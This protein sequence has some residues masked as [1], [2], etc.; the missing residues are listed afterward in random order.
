MEITIKR[1]I[2][3]EL[4]CYKIRVKLTSKGIRV[5]IV[6]LA[7]FVLSIVV[8]QNDYGITDT[9]LMIYLFLQIILLAFALL[10]FKNMYVNR[11][12]YKT[13]SKSA[14]VDYASLETYSTTTIDDKYLT[15]ESAR[16]YYKLS[17]S[18]LTLYQL[19]DGNLILMINSI[20]NSFVIRP[21]ELS[22]AEFS[23]LIIFASKNLKF[24]K[25]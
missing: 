9:S 20:L 1:N 18:S 5:G 16:K 11:K 8:C 13:F 10:I 17:W 4:A 2:A 15:Y 21:T 19:Y 25:R 6:T 22:P 14:L 12:Q 3:E 24:K 7:L 23:N